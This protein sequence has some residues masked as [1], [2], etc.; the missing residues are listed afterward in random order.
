MHSTLLFELRKN[1]DHGDNVAKGIASQADDIWMPLNQAAFKRKIFSSERLC[2]LALQMTAISGTSRQHML[3]RIYGYCLLLHGYCHGYHW[4][5]YNNDDAQI[6]IAGV[7]FDSL[8]F[9]VNFLIATKDFLYD[10]VCATNGDLYYRT[11]YSIL[12]LAIAEKIVS[13]AAEQV[14]ANLDRFRSAFPDSLSDTVVWWNC[15]LPHKEKATI[16]NQSWKKLLSA[17]SDMVVNIRRGIKDL[18]DG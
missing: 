12:Q 9:D 18:G 15:F 10:C 8:F 11:A 17:A 2:A 6:F 1:I 16:S 13:N 7:A 4:N 5:A 3:I 14:Q